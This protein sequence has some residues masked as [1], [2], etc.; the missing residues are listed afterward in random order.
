ML[1][2]EITA[3]IGVEDGGDATG[4][5]AW[6]FFAPDSLTKGQG[7]GERRGWLETESVSHDHP[8]VIVFDRR[9]VGFGWFAF[10]VQQPHIQWSMIRLPHGIGMGG[11][12][13]E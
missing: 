5:P 9:E 13:S 11:F 8:A 7:G 12:S 3:M 6:V 4:R 1:T 2:G 10:L